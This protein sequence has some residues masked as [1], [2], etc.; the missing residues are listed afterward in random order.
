MT[1]IVVDSAFRATL[2][3]SDGCLEICDQSGQTIGYFHPVVK[4]ERVANSKPQSP[5]S[6]EELEVRRRDRSGKPLAEILDRLSQL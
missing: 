5:F 6:K 4:G 2:T 1:K 3:Q